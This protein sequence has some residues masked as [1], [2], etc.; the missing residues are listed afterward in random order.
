MLGVIFVL[1]IFFNLSYFMT[2]GK[3]IKLM[4]VGIIGHLI[5]IVSLFDTEPC[6]F[7]LRQQHL[8]SD[9]YDWSADSPESIYYKDILS[10]YIATALVGFLTALF[11]E[12]LGDAIVGFVII[13]LS[14]VVIYMATFGPLP[15]LL[16]GG[17][18]L[19]LVYPLSMLAH[20]RRY[21]RSLITALIRLSLILLTMLAPWLTPVKATIEQWVA[22]IESV[23]LIYALLFVVLSFVFRRYVVLKNISFVSSMLANEDVESIKR[24]TSDPRWP[25]VVEFAYRVRQYHIG[26]ISAEELQPLSEHLGI[27]VPPPPLDHADKEDG[28]A[29]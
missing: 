20:I 10:R 14:G 4:I 2:S 11:A 24:I 23:P 8:I 27:P 21:Q 22:A 19:G 26:E 25:S 3:I 12:T 6:Y 5:A 7:I 18:R 9:G 17:L 29:V 1:A 15:E 28:Q 16:Y 13:E